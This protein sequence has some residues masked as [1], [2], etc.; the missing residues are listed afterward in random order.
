M[1][2]GVSRRMDALDF[3]RGTAKATVR[4]S[5]FDVDR[6]LT[7]HST[8]SPFLFFA[9]RTT[10]PWRLVFVPAVV[11]AMLCYRLGLIERKRLKEMM[12]AWMLGPRLSARRAAHLASR[13]ADRLM[14]NDVY[15]DGLELIRAERAAGRRIVLATAANDFYLKALAE[16]LGIADVIATR[17]R[18]E[19][20]HLLA[21]ISGENCHGRS[22]LDMIEAF[23]DEADLGRANTHIRF[24]SDHVSDRP[25]FEWADDPIAVNPSRRLRSLA[26]KERWKILNWR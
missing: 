21:R 10:A 13:F 25:V 3:R 2:G 22:K 11:A 6:T 20:G 19:Q 17:S 16:K 24:Y 1:D 15:P 9:A 14:A 18:W 12:H 26:R 5:I 8:W 4:L 7:R 23:L